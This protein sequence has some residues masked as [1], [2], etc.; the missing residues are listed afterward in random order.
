MKKFLI[1]FCFTLIL[2]ACDRFEHNFTTENE[3]YSVEEFFTEFS[4][5]ISQLPSEDV[6]PVMN[7]YHEDY[8]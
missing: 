5:Q 8:K 1:I 3:S 7:F 4:S 6:T 2:F